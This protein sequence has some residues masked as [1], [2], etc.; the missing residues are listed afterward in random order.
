MLPPEA[1]LLAMTMTVRPYV[2]PRPAEAQKP[3]AQVYYGEEL[4]KPFLPVLPA[5]AAFSVPDDLRD[6]LNGSPGAGPGP[7]WAKTPASLLLGGPGGALLHEVGLGS[8][9]EDDGAVR[10]DMRGGA[11]ADGRFAWHWQSVETRLPGRVERAPE[12]RRVLVVLGSRGQLLFKDESADA[13][14]G[15]EPAVMSRDGETLLA[16]G[17]GPGGWAATAY[18]FT[19]KE[20]AVVAGAHRLEALEL[21]PDGRRALV[22]W[23]GLDQPLMVTLLD[24]KAD[25]RL[26]IPADGL[27]PGPWTL[28]PDGTL[29]AAGKPARRP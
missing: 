5:A 14:A 20:L 19:G 7:G 10:R 3:P 23:A 29:L 12:S 21:S 8:F 17:R 1:F 26:D 11:S 25:E 4:P 9:A 15:L 13:P 24:L 28:G 18:S 2:P 22:A 27:P 16:A 6:S